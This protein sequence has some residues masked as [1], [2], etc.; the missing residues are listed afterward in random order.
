MISSAAEYAI[1]AMLCLATRG[2]A[3]HGG[4]TTHHISEAATLPLAYLAKVMQMLVRAQLVHSQRGI[5]GGFVLARPPESIT[6]LDVVRA[7]EPSH[8]IKTC[9]VGH[10][11]HGISL[12]PLHR[13]LDAAARCVEELLG[14]TSLEQLVEESR[15]H[16]LLH[17]VSL[18]TAS[19]QPDPGASEMP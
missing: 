2:P 7:V 15:Q 16:A 12:C 13:R 5:N 11:G 1:R 18:G 8:R 9:P 6:L 14:G 10:A 3:G 4:L 17:P 19:P